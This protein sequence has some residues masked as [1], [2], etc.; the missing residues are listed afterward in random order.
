MPPKK[1]EGA[2]YKRII[3]DAW[4]VAW[5]HKHLWVFGF[6]ATAVGFGGVSEALFSSSDRVYA[7]FPAIT[8]GKSGLQMLPGFATIKAIIN[9]TSYPALSL[10]LFLAIM[11]TLVGVFLWMGYAAAGGLVHSIRKIE[12]AGEPTFGEG[13]KLGAEKFW[14]V[15][16]VNVLTQPIIFVG[17]M[18][19]TTTLSVLMR[20]RTISSGIFYVG[21]FILF[22]VLAV[23]AS[24]A[25]IYATCFAIIKDKKLVPALQAGWKLLYDHWFV[26]L[27]MAFFLFL[28]SL[29]IGITAVLISLIISVPFIF[30]LL[31]V[32]MMH[33]SAA[34]VLVLMVAS[35]LMLAMIV[36]VGSFITVF[37]VSAWTLLWSEMT[38]RKPLPK[39]RRLARHISPHF[40]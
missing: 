30:L 21:T 1:S 32:A 33:L 36:C 23:S 11:G 5:Q 25:A 38:E 15:F 39:L 34:S 19:T 26:T 20:D 9:F 31:V 22:V 40:G 16:G 37:Q 35:A 2:F 17:S 14:R 10:L 27:E 7:F 13:L 29:G 6:L 28:A 8:S 12:R 4:R 24:V 3:T 18:L